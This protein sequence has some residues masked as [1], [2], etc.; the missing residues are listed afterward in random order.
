MVQEI[1]R[2]IEDGLGFL[3]HVYG[4]DYN[5]INVFCFV[6]LSFSRA[7]KT[8]NKE[9]EET[10]NESYHNFATAVDSF[11]YT[12]ANINSFCIYVTNDCIALAVSRQGVYEVGI[13]LC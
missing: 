10:D 7:Y 1:I 2:E 6:G 3:L 12:A 8:D 9:I 4:S 13:C 11:A 5:T